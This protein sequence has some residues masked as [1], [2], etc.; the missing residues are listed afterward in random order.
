MLTSLSIYHEE[1]HRLQKLKTEIEGRLIRQDEIEIKRILNAMNEVIS[2]EAI[3]K[4][5]EWKEI[6]LKHELKGTYYTRSINEKFKFDSP[7]KENLEK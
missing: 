4:L 3:Q 6:C 5:A 1:K 7:Q 2:D